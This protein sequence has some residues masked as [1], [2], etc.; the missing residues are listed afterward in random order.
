LEDDLIVAA[1]DDYDLNLNQVFAE[2]KGRIK[3]FLV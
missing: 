2:S 3:Q 1:D